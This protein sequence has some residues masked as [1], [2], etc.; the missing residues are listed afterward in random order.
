M[1]RKQLVEPGSPQNEPHFDEEWTVLSAR[2]VV[3]LADLE[4]KEKRRY[5]V[6][7][8]GA[9]VLASSLGVL[10]ALASIRI[11]ELNSRVPEGNGSQETV[12]STAIDSDAA[13]V[14]ELAVQPNEESSTPVALDTTEEIPAVLTTRPARVIARKHQTATADLSTAQGESESEPVEAKPQPRLVDQWQEG[15]PRRVRE[16]RPGNDDG[17]HHPRDLRDLDEIFEGSTKKP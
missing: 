11:R 9:F 4:A 6:K 7:L 12:A 2:P 14:E 1:L 17:A 5:S 13:P 16:R 10:V 15:R 3:P 8:V